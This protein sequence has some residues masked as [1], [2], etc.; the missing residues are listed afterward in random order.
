[1]ADLEFAKTMDALKASLQ[2]ISETLDENSINSNEQKF[3]ENIID[4]LEIFFRGYIDYR[5]EN[6]EKI[7][8]KSMQKPVKVDS[9]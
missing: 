7:V 2:E 9:S 3:R 8:Q 6:D 5:Q 4:A 1:M